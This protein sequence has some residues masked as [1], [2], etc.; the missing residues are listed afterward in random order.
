MYNFDEI[1]I[2]KSSSCVK[3]DLLQE[4]FGND[5]LIPLWVADMDFRA[6]DF[7]TDALKKRLDHPVFGYGFKPDNYFQTIAQWV[8]DIH[9]WDI[10]PEEMH[11]IP[12]IVK[13]IGFVVN[14]LLEK[15]EKVIIQPPVYHP[16]RLVPGSYGREVLYNPLIPVYEDG[17]GRIEDMC[18]KDRD[19]VL[20]GYEMDFESLEK[21]IDEKT[22]LLILANPHNPAGICWS[23]KTL[24]KLAKITSRH[25]IIV[26]SDEIH[27]EM[28]HGNKRHFPYASVS[29]EAAGNA[30]TFMSPSKT[31]NIAGI[32]S[33]YVIVKN[34]ELRKKLFSWLDAGELDMASIFSVTAT[35]AAY[36]HG[37][38]WRKEMLEYVGA[39]I[40]FVDDY[41]KENI[42]QI[43]CLKPQASFLVWLDCRSLNLPQEELCRIVIEKAGLALNDGTMFSSKNSA[44]EA[45]EF[46]DE[47]KGF[48]RLNVAC[49]KST[50]E[51]ALNQ[52]KNAFI[53]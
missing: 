38:Q 31:F 33:S 30:I 35:I 51:K 50:L 14:A 4:Y 52:L 29:E 7:I 28:V 12:G 44:G 18:A 22:K 2:R 10:N 53:I 9:V 46:R 37:H 48:M 3:Y 32:I 25:G 23:K 13:G 20:M 40:D 39:N 21:I 26:I 34:P 49:P 47:G 27:C 11:Y 8:K 36:T 17:V 5:N 15:D 41:L 43:R 16:F 42:P 24:Q 45:L 19:R 1:I 6:A